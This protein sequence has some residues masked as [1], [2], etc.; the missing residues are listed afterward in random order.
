MEVQIH[1]ALAQLQR[2][3]HTQHMLGSS[4]KGATAKSSSRFLASKGSYASTAAPAHLDKV[5]SGRDLD[6][7][8]VVGL[9]HNIVGE[10]DGLR[11]LHQPQSA[12]HVVQQH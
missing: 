2:I 4:V 6:G 9:K 7:T 5:A 8:V 10:V 1:R 12:L 11:A 3:H